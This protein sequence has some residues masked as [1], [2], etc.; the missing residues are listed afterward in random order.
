MS[1]GPI[2]GRDRELL[3]LDAVVAEL[4]DRP[5]L[6]L[7][8]EPGIGIS[9]LLDA[10]G[11]RA[12]DRGVRVVT[13]R[14]GSVTLDEVHG[15]LAAGNDRRQ[16]PTLLL[17]DDGDHVDDRGWDALVHAAPRFVGMPFAVVVALG[18]GS[19]RARGEDLPVLRVGPLTEPAA[20]AVLAE[21]DT[22]LPTFITERIVEAAAG[23]PMALVELARATPAAWRRQCVRP[24]I[25]LP[26][27]PRLIR[28]LAAEVE[29]LPLATREVLLAAA[30]NDSTSLNE[31]V[32]AAAARLKA[33]IEET[34]AAG[35][36]AFTHRIVEGDGGTIRFRSEAARSAIYQAASL[37]RRHGMHVA[38]SRLLAKEPY[39][40]AWHRAA[41][42][43][44]PDEALAEQLSDAANAV[45]ERGRIRD[46]LATM[47]RAA[48]VSQDPF[49]RVPRLL[50]AAELAYEIGRAD[51][52]ATFLGQAENAAQTSEHRHWIAM[53]QGLYDLWRPDDGGQAHELVAA[54]QEAYADGDAMWTR[55]LLTQLVEKA[56]ATRADRAP[57]AELLALADRIGEIEDA[58][59]LTGPLSVVCPAERGAEVLEYLRAA[60]EDAD[61]D[62]LLAR[63]HGD[64]A[65][66]LGDADLALPFLSASID[67]LREEGRLGL[68]PFA[69]LDRARCHLATAGC[70]AVVADLDEGLKLADETAQPFLVGCFRALEARIAGAEGDIARAEVLADAA[71]RAADGRGA[72]LVDVHLARGRSRLAAEDA[73]GAFT[74][75]TALWDADLPLM[76]V[77]RRWAA[78][79]DLAEAA[80]AIGRAEE[81]RPLVEALTLTAAA[82]PS[83]LLR[84]TL[85]YARALLD[86]GDNV[87]GDLRTAR[88]AATARG[89]FSA[90][91][92]HLAYGVWLRR[93]QRGEEARLELEAAVAS[94]DAAGATGWSTR[95]HDALRTVVDG[96]QRW[97]G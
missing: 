93:H 25:A 63:V 52:V 15:L 82:V 27:S 97:A 16:P 46:A 75:L 58:P 5:G 60:P 23:N 12:A 29:R 39:R 65:M 86:L 94:F 38:L 53:L 90:G 70:D 64:A 24:P 55:T 79:G 14:G 77:S 31:A 9:A 18:D 68:L 56:K 76:A 37:P 67:Q 87:E 11:R 45:R 66:T 61:G 36:A 81:V 83:P 57:K 8:G 71:E 92:V 84:V 19:P 91:R 85:P 72:L 34:L 96:S 33:G 30:A 47:D 26:L 44:M 28:G 2:H 51:I 62:P 32:R 1:F 74:A 21:V 17:L 42:S 41:A 13:A 54:A 69:L 73:D 10:A 59:A 4:S 78:I 49:A 50:E 40:A 89:P 20:R 43:L 7:A 95:A 88:A 48:Q 80:A 3:A 35:H 22:G 6:V